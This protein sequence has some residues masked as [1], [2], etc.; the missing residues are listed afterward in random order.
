MS[1]P[2]QKLRHQAAK[3]AIDRLTRLFLPGVSS[4]DVQDRFRKMLTSGAL[5]ERRL[6]VTYSAAGHA[7]SAEPKKVESEPRQKQPEVLTVRELIQRFTDQEFGR[8]TSSILAKANEER[9]K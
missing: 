7:H 8:L 5:A 3:A 1:D 9:C 4:A 2:Q 6:C